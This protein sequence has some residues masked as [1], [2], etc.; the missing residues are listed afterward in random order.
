MTSITARRQLRLRP[1]FNAVQNIAGVDWESSWRVG[2]A[3]DEAAG[4]APARRHGRQ[5]L[6]RE[7]GSDLQHDRRA[8]GAAVR[9]RDDDALTQDA[10]ESLA[11]QVEGLIFGWTP[12][13]QLVSKFANVQSDVAISTQGNRPVG[14]VDIKIACETVETFAPFEQ[15]VDLRELGLHLDFQTVAVDGT[16]TYV[17]P[18]FPDAVTAA[19]RTSGP[20][21]RDEGRLEF[22]MQSGAPRLIYPSR[23]RVVGTDVI[24]PDG[25]S[26]NKLR[27]YSWGRELFAREQDAID[28]KNMGAKVIRIP[29][30]WGGPYDPTQGS[31]DARDGSNPALGYFRQQ[32]LDLFLAR[33]QWCVA[34]GLYWVP[35][36][37]TNC[38]QNA[39]Q[40]GQT[41]TTNTYCSIGFGSVTDWPLGHNFFT[42]PVYKAQYFAAWAYLGRLIA[43]IPGLAMVEPTPELN[44]AAAGATDDDYVTYYRQ[45]TAVIRQ[46]CPGAPFIVG[47]ESYGSGT[48]KQAYDKFA[49]DY[50]YTQNAYLHAGVADPL[51]DF[52][53][54]LTRLTDLR[55]NKVV[56]VWL[57]Q[58]G[59]RTSEDTTGNP[60]LQA[61][62]AAVLAANV[63]GAYWSYRDGN[64]SSGFGQIWTDNQGVDHPK[65]EEIALVQSWFQAA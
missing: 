57:Q 50:V 8:R 13:V 48:P 5:D 29:L 60:N 20:D 31:E 4:R 47:A 14:I 11:E 37:D 12:L 62:L 44:W 3:A 59:R 43:N 64:F 33:V 21:G 49:T 28:A 56:P 25:S 26:I 10:L 15:P 34:Q 6:R 30:R 1:R 9:Q 58:F 65:T 16:G 53:T 19:P 51:A 52:V 32:D 41:G 42:D 36:L 45:V 22:D 27:G 38:G 17:Y 55:T 35:F 24:L 23:A 63:G 39:L 40:D 7:G 2:R 18:P 61:I 54:R 46:V